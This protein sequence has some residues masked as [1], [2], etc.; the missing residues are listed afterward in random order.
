MPE[1]KWNSQALIDQA[2]GKTPEPASVPFERLVFGKMK[3]NETDWEILLNNGFSVTDSKLSEDPVLLKP[4]SSL[5]LGDWFRNPKDQ[6]YQLLPSGDEDTALVRAHVRPQQIIAYG[7]KENFVVNIHDGR[8]F[9]NGDS[10]RQDVWLTDEN[11]KTN[12]SKRGRELVINGNEVK[13]NHHVIPAG[14]ET[15]HKSHGRAI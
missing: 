10:I 7:S 2:L 15:V 11:V 6:F 9:I 3:V 4:D 14:E 1:E 13:G 5:S 8:A 12:I